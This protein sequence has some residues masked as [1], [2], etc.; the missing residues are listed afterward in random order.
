MST[1]SMIADEFKIKF[2]APKD[3]E[4][5]DGHVISHKPYKKYLR[6]VIINHFFNS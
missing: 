6:T 2:E 1:Q 5:H 3:W 4:C